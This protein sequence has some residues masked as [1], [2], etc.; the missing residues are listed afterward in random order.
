MKGGVRAS[1]FE[2]PRESARLLTMRIYL[3][4]PVEEPANSN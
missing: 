4:L 2:T 1:R 3:K